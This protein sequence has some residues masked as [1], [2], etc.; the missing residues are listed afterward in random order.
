MHCVQP[1]RDIVRRAL[2]ACTVLRIERN[3]M[4]R[5]IK[6]KRAFAVLF[7]DYLL[8]RITRY[9]EVIMDQ[10]FVSSE[11][12]LPVPAAT[13]QYERK[14]DWRR[15]FRILAKR[16]CRSVGTTGRGELLHESL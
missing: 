13:Y 11:K 1:P 8:S 5:M 9:Q 7:V 15:W 6:T 10:M 4:L 3:E 16:Y 12:R 14:R 2:T